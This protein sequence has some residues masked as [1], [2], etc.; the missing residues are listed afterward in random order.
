MHIKSSYS[1][2]LEDGTETIPG[3]VYEVS[4]EEGRT[5]IYRGHASIAPKGKSSA[6]PGK[7]LDGR[8]TKDLH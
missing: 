1:T 3:E 6:S 7:E 2:T 4:T 8:S 5:L